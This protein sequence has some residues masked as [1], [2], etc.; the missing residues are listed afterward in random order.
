MFNLK[1]EFLKK[2][3]ALKIINSETFS[4]FKNINLNN[5]L[6]NS[7]NDSFYFLIELIKILIG[8][9]EIKK[10]TINFLS[11]HLITVENAIKILLK[12]LLNTEFL[13]NTNPIIPDSYIDEGIYIA[14]SQIDFFKILKVDPNS[15]TGKFVYG[16]ESL[17][18]NA[19]L[20]GVINS[21]NEQNWKSVLNVSYV[22]NNIVDGNNTSDVLKIRIDESYRNKPILTFVN[23]FID[24]IALLS[25][26]LLI[27]RIF[28]NLFGVF[29]L[30]MG[31]SFEQ[32]KN[33]ELFNNTIEKILNEPSEL[34]NDSYFNF[35]SNEIEIINKKAQNTLQGT[36]YLNHCNEI[37]T[38]PDED[39]LSNLNDIIVT[40]SYQ[41]I[42]ETINDNFTLI[43]NHIT[44]DVPAKNKNNSV[45]EFYSSFFKGIIISIVNIFFSPKTMLL[46]S[47]Y[48]KI[49]NNTIGFIN[50]NDFLEKNR[51]FVIKLIRNTIL[52]ILLNFLINNTVKYLKKLALQ[53]QLNKK[54]E[55]ARY[56]QLQYQSLL[57]IPDN[58]SSFLKN[59]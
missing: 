16:S 1:Q 43:T 51:E 41:E 7:K 18:L 32:L 29:S 54:A 55:Q 56:Y 23:N 26:S 30:K 15:Q 47:L 33:E 6:L 19:F 25:L 46:F 31:K 39:I 45:L 8:W 24:S 2:I 11:Y 50:L 40:S 49:V 12:K 34:Y 53:E 27:N 57:G 38:T 48:F 21:P 3:A 42:S 22:T 36:R 37:L 35:T 52:P 20:Y 59:L 10:I 17:D 44:K 9:E 14:L 4:K 58:I 5:S 13:C 28:D